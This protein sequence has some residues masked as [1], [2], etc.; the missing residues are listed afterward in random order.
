MPMSYPT[1][2]KIKA[3]RRYENKESIKELC[4]ELDVSQSTLYHGRKQYCTIQT[5]IRSYTPAEFHAIA[6]RLKKLGHML[7]IIRLSGFLARVP[8]QKKLPLLEHLH[9]EMGNFYTIKEL[10]EALEVAR[11]TFYNHIFRRAD[12]QNIKMKKLSIA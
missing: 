4:Q 3:V 12:P 10:C 1:E 7:E 5:A 2:F 6:K 8:L 9:N 11:D